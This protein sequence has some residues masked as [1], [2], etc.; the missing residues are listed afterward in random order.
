LLK[1]K[2]NQVEQ[3]Q[4][5]VDKVGYLTQL[6]TAKIDSTMIDDISRARLLLK[7][8]LMSNP[9]NADLW[10]SAARVELMDRKMDSAR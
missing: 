9:K 4:S 10:V 3:K 6:N 7:S 1:S 2:L 8:A 5:T